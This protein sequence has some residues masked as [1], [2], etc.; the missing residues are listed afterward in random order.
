MTRSNKHA[1]VEVVN[2][3]IGGLSFPLAEISFV[4]FIICAGGTD[5][6]EKL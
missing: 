3:K 4:E 1:R 2:F 5:N 6:G